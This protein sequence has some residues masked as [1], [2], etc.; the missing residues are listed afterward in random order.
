MST[1]AL[2]HAGMHRRAA[3]VVSAWTH[4]AWLAGGLAL[5]FTLPFLLVDTL[6]LDRDLFYGLYGAAVLAYVAAW[7]RATGQ[8]WRAAIRRRWRLTAALTVLASIVLVLIVYRTEDATSRPE[9]IEFVAGSGADAGQTIFHAHVHLIPRY[10]GDHPNPR[11]GVRHI[12]PGKG[13]YP[14]D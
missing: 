5:G 1:H 14:A 8:S 12:I 10:R 9:G 4:A 2:G 13:D 6:G 7:G 3:G 11:G